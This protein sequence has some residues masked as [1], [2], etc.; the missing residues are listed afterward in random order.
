MFETGVDPYDILSQENLSQISDESSLK[1]TAE[2]I[3]KENPAAVADYKKGKG[4]ALQFLI[5]KAMAELKGRGNP[6][7]LRA[8]FEKL[9]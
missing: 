4:N 9:L 1:T 2:K 5:G 6:E 3:I 8:V 7:M